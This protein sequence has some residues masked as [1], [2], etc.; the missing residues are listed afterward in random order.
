MIMRGISFVIIVDIM[1]ALSTIM[2]H[3]ES[4]IKH[5]HGILC[6]LMHY[7]LTTFAALL[8]VF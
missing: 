3:G 5:G 2:R 8:M 7:T 6:I 4:S 1:L